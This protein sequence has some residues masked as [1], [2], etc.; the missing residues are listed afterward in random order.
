MAGLQ[1]LGCQLR[2]V[3]AFRDC[4]TSLA[5]VTAASDCRLLIM[6]RAAFRRLLG[7]FPHVAQ[8][9]AAMGLRCSLIDRWRHAELVQPVSLWP[10]CKNE[11]TAGHG[12]AAPELRSTALV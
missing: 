11:C 2:D 3:T 6:P 5:T 4:F 1:E 7:D 8:R 12:R 10:C 9:L